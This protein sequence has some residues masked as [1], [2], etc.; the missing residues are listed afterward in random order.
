MIVALVP[1]KFWTQMFSGIDFY[2]L[3]QYFSVEKIEIVEYNLS[4][5]HAGLYLKDVRIWI[6]Y[7]IKK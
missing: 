2:T 7:Q 1:S 5:S 6:N 3:F 4:W